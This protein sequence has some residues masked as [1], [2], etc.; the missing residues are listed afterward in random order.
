MRR[1]GDQ[2]PSF[3]KVSVKRPT[4]IP[5]QSKLGASDTLSYDGTASGILLEKA[6]TADDS[7][8]VVFSEWTSEADEKAYA[9]L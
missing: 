6:P 5:R 9:N 4:A 1:I 3:S 2:R 7:L 8:L